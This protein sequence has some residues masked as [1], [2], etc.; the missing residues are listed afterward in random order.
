MFNGQANPSFGATS[1]HIQDVINIILKNIEAQKKRKIDAQ[2]IQTVSGIVK[3]AYDGVSKIAQKNRLTPEQ[4][5]A[6]VMIV[7]KNTAARSGIKL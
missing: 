7:I 4:E 1:S 3:M 6:A 2:D 5:D